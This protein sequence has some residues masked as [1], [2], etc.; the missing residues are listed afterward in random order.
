MR[1]IKCS[2]CSKEYATVDNYI[3]HIKKSHSEDIPEGW[4]AGHF[5][6]FLKTGKKNG[7]C[8]MCKSPTEFNEAT[9]KYSRFCSNPVCKERYRE[10]FKKRMI[11]KYGKV[12][13]LD[14]PEQQKKMLANRSISGQY[15]WSDGTLKTYTGSYELSFLEFLDVTLD[16][17][18]NDVICPS[19]HTYWYNYEGKKHFYIPDVFIP[20]LNLEIE[21]KDGGNNPNMH[22]KIQEVDKV[23]EKLKDEVMKSNGNNFDYIKVVN[24]QNDIFLKYLS[25]NN[26]RMESDDKNKKPI[27]I[28]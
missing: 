8:V 17:D 10:M 21:I 13:L 23:K 26:I 22:H 20:S 25:M 14:D 24:K 9:L 2:L 1:P 3:A 16:F 27:F 4:S 11:G 7:S 12:S 5:Y 6:Y 28:I 15:K 18:S 19:P